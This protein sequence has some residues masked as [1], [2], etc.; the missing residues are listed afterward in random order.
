[1]VKKV[2]QNFKVPKLTTEQPQGLRWTLEKCR[3]FLF[4]AA[5]ACEACPLC[6]T[7]LSL[8]GASDIHAM[9]SAFHAAQ[10]TYFNF[11]L[12]PVPM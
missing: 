3:N 4:E 2:I 11:D 12:N 1:M 8:R 10:E 6:E 5:S 9:T 7:H